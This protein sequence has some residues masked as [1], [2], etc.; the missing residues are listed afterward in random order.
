MHSILKNGGQLASSSSEG[1]ITKSLWPLVY[2]QNAHCLHSSELRLAFIPDHS[3]TSYPTLLP[4]DSRRGESQ[5]QRW[6]GRS[7]PQRG[8]SPGQAHLACCGCCAAWH[9][10]GQSPGLEPCCQEHRAGPPGRG[11]GE[12]RA[13]I[14]VPETSFSFL[15]QFPINAGMK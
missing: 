7:S 5:G 8:C 15:Y 1:C 2:L 9:I 4:T 3:S 13:P 11:L 14:R 12:R 10:P 6:A